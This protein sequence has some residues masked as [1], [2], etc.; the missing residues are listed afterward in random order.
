MHYAYQART[1]KVAL[2]WG[3]N[4]TRSAFRRMEWEGLELSGDDATNPDTRCFRDCTPSPASPLTPPNI[5]PPTT[6]CV[7]HGLG[8]N[9]RYLRSEYF[10]FGPLNFHRNHLKSQ[11][12]SPP[13]Y[14]SLPGLFQQTI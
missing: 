9:P 1:G 4:D 3:S 13:S 2:F 8:F 5:N 12:S 10:P 14:S 6:T 7:I 11:A